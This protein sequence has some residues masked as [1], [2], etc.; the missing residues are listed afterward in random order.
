MTVVLEKL[1]EELAHLALCGVER[2]AS[3]GSNPVHAPGGAA[4]A[5]FY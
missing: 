1:P 5:S 2:A 4:E 3:A